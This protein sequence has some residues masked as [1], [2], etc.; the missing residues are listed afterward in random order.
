M[1]LKSLLERDKMLTFRLSEAGDIKGIKQV[2]KTCF[3]DEDAYIDFFFE[4]IYRP[5]SFM[6]LLDDGMIASMTAAF[7]QRLAM[8]GGRSLPVMYLYAFATAPEYRGRHCGEDLMAYAAEYLEKEGYAAAIVVPGDKGLFDYYEGLGF[9]NSFYLLERDFDNTG[10]E[11]GRAAAAQKPAAQHAADSAPSAQDAAASD[12][13]ARDSAVSDPS[14]RDI[15]ITPAAPEEYNSLRERLL[16]NTDHIS[17]DNDILRYQKGLLQNAGGDLF[18]LSSD[19]LEGCMAME[20]SE[21]GLFIKELLVMGLKD[22]P[23]SECINRV[24]TRAA[25][26]FSC[27][28]GK[29]RMPPFHHA[30][31]SNAED[32][33]PFAMIR[34]LGSAAAPAE[35][36]LAFAFD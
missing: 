32:K 2:W 31:E 5:G 34:M 23:F 7:P 35:G 6:L 3:G 30:S 36:Y 10:R 25:G 16:D 19:D 27:E 14:A 20:R 1:I 9:K 22:I 28:R 8:T 15:S 17:Y 12:P 29:L 18:R 24:L 33:R 4:N 13:S 21:E 26:L 11:A